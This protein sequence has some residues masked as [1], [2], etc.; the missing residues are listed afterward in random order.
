MQTRFDVIEKQSSDLETQLQLLDTTHLTIKRIQSGVDDLMQRVERRINEMVEMQ[1]L[2]EERF[3][4]EWTTFK[5]DD[6]KRW[7]NYT[8]SQEEQRTEV[9]RRFDRMS[10]QVT[11]L[12][13]TLQELQDIMYQVNEMTNKRLQFLLTAA[14][15]WVN[16]YE[17]VHTPSR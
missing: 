15:D 5:A 12:E 17:R 6:Q 10:D 11:N 14:H 7:T 9:G 13:D 4:Q 2:A 1:R 3:R 16:E 8:L